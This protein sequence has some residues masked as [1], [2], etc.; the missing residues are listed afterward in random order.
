[1]GTGTVAENSAAQIP[2]ATGI[3][4]WPSDEPRIIASRRGEGLPPDF[5]ALPGDEEVLLSRTGTLF[6]WTTQEFAPPS[7]PYHG[8]EKFE[9]YAV[10]YVEFPEGVLVEGRIATS[11]FGSLSIGMPMS[12]VVVPFRTEADGTVI[13]TYAFAPDPVSAEGEELA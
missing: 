13:V 7:P 6:T 1:M 8:P 11:D 5:P 4:T 10:G 2:V 3:F 9:P 12:V